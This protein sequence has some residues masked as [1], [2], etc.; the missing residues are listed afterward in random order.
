MRCQ[1]KVQHRYLCVERAAYALV[2][3]TEGRLACRQH[4][5]QVADELRAK[6]DNEGALI[7]M[8]A[9]NREDAK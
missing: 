6:A 4:M 5:A 3:G 7:K 2:V 1:G 8:V 9:V